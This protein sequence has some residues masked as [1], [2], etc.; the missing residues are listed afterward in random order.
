MVTAPVAA[1]SVPRSKVMTKPGLGMAFASCPRAVW[2]TRPCP[3]CSVQMSGSSLPVPQPSL[4]LYQF[5]G[6]SKAL[7]RTWMLGCMESR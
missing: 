1:H 7:A 2:K 6:S 5:L 4:G 3:Y